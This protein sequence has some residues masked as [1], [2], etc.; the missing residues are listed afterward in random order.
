MTS[1]M[2]S[3]SIGDSWTIMEHV[4]TMSTGVPLAPVMLIPDTGV[5]I[6]PWVYAHFQVTR[7][8]EAPVSTIIA[9]LVDGAPGYIWVT[10]TP[11]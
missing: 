10:A 7:V 3:S 4:P 1:P 9:P 5:I 6:R 11:R 8:M 2:S